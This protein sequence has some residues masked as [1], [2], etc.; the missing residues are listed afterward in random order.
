MDCNLPVKATSTPDPEILES[1]Q[2]TPLEHLNKLRIYLGLCRVLRYE[3]TAD[4]QNVSI[5]NTAQL[6]GCIKVTSIIE[7]RTRLC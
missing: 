5:I 7:I 4:V 2:Q 3:M 1:L 6:C